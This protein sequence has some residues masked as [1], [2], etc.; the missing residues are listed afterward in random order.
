MGQDD[1]LG[2]SRRQLLAGASGV[3][4]LTALGLPRRAAATAAAG[5]DLG[6][7]EHVVFLMMENRSYDHYFGTYPRGRGF[8]DHPPHRLGSFA[9]AY[10]KGGQ[11]DPPDVL[12]P[13]RLTRPADECTKDLTHNWGPMHQ[14]W[15]HGRMDSFVRVHTSAAH[16]GN[17][18]GA[19]TMGYY[20]REEL[21]FYYSLA[22]HF[23]LADGYFCSILGPTHPNR[24]MSVSG[25]IDPAGQHG[26]PITDTDPDPRVRWTCDWPTVQELLEDKGVSWK[27]YHPSNADLATLGADA[28]KFADLAAYPIWNPALY[29]PT[30]NPTVMLSTDNVLPYFKAFENP[31]TSL[32]RKAFLPTFPADFI[33]DVKAGSLPRV[34]WLIPPL[35]FDEHAS[36]SPDHGMWFTSAVLEALADNP[37]VWSKTVLFLMYDEND[38]M[39]DHV[40]PPTPPK[41]T[42][43]EW[44]TAPSISNTTSGI[45]GPLGLGVRVPLLVISPFSRGGHIASETFDHTSQ[46]KFLEERFDIRIPDIS[47]WRRRTVGDLTSTLFRSRPNASMPALHPAPALGA[48]TFT[49]PCAEQNQETE[50][51]GGSD[52]TLPRKQRMPTQDGRTVSPRRFKDV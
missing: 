17:P 13:F 8:D 4:A 36:A 22:D 23:T 46:L 39:F 32:Y 44:L 15:N 38:G 40:P 43:G 31:S 9:Q 7:I 47:A 49:G 28:T 1:D 33:N 6:A 21:G 35:S 11:L 30:A 20:T 27:V 26:G 5:S 48:P 51:V 25:T 10:P 41:G 29:D 16:E 45:R 52:P 19:L 24:V 12:L 34:S 14:C 42:P 2:L 50:F 3:A 37:K 18:T